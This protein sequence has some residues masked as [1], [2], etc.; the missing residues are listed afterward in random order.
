M[1][2]SG[3]N[4]VCVVPDERTPGMADTRVTIFSTTS[5]RDRTSEY[6]AGGSSICI[7]S[8]RAAS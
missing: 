2:S 4:V 3:M 6:F 8:T 7:V 5:A 1:L